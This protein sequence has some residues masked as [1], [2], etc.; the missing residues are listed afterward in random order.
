MRLNEHCVGLVLVAALLLPASHAVAEDP[1]ARDADYWVTRI[2]EAMRIGETLSAQ[3]HVEVNHPGSE[4]DFAFDMHVLRAREGGTTRTVM[5]MREVGDPK[6]IVTELVEKPDEPLTSWYWD[7]QKRRWLAVR[8]LQA[9]DPFA[10]TTFRYEDLWFT[11]PSARR[12]GRVKWVEEGGRRLVAIESDPYHYYL[13]VV[14]IIDPEN[15]LPVRVRFIDNTGTPIREQFYERSTL[16][17]GAPFP[18]VVRHRDLM[19]GSETTIT[20]GDVR[21]GM[22]IPPSFFDLSV[23][24]DR[25]RR[26]IDPV[27][28]P[29]DLLNRPETASPGESESAP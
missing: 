17:D 29:P 16:V 21:F 6:S 5:E 1:D 22:R 4:E 8:G 15:G 13:R 26:G 9:T 19:T 11:E 20:Y 7:L 27:P 14:T 18:S 25:I 10:D 3:A 24:D 2:G 12:S 28:D 23:I